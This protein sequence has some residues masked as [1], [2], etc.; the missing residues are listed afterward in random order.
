MPTNLSLQQEQILLRDPS[1][2]RR[3]HSNLHAIRV[4]HQELRIRRLERISHLLNIVSVKIKMKNSSAS[5]L[6]IIQ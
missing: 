6:P 2:L 1:I 3:L 4:R 5:Q